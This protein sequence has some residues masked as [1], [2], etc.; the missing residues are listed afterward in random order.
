M[1]NDLT[2]QM[3]FV[4]LGMYVLH[5]PMLGHRIEEKISF[6][7]TDSQ[8]VS[9]QCHSR[10]GNFYVHFLEF[11]TLFDISL[12]PYSLNLIEIYFNSAEK[13]NH[14]RCWNYL[15]CSRKMIL[16]KWI[17]SWG[18]YVPG[19]VLFQN[20]NFHHFNLDLN[21]INDVMF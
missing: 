19:L 2:R 9:S 18:A 10:E 1:K 21:V 14:L 13:P 4:V 17:C 8:S 6:C 12:N 20:N 3:C 11:S 15:K 5:I 16:L 7:T